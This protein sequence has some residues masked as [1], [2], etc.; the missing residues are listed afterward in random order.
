MDGSEL[1]SS[2][3]RRLKDSANL[4]WRHVICDALGLAASVTDRVI[5][6]E[7][8]HLD[9][10]ST[11][12][13][14]TEVHEI[15]PQYQNL[16]RIHCATFDIRGGLYEDLPIIKSRDGKDHH[17][18][19]NLLV[20]DFYRYA[21]RQP[22]ISFAVIHEF[23]CCKRLRDGTIVRNPTELTKEWGESLILFSQDLYRALRKL[24]TK[25]APSAPTPD[26]SAG[27]E[28]LNWH[29]WAFRNLTILQKLPD[30]CDGIEK[31][32]A[33]V[34][35]EYFCRSKLPDFESIKKLISSGHFSRQLL[36][37][38]FA[39][40]DIVLSKS[41][42]GESY[43]MCYEL[44]G[45][46]SYSDEW[47]LPSDKSSIPS[48]GVTTETKLELSHWLFDGNFMKETSSFS[49]KTTIEA[50]EVPITSLHIMPLTCLTPEKQSSLLRRG[51]MFWECRKMRHVTY[52]GWDF[53]RIENFNNVRFVIDPNLSKACYRHDPERP[54]QP[55]PELV[56]NLGPEAMSRTESPGDKFL[57]ATPNFVWG[58]NLQDKKWC[59]LAIAHVNDV[60]WDEKAFDNLVID[61]D[62][63]DV[64]QALV[65]NKVHNSTSTDLVRGKGGGL[66]LLLHG[67]PGTGKTL[68]AE[69]VAEHA[70]KPIYKVTCGDIG[71]KPE[72]V[73]GY[74]KKV[75][76]LGKTW[77]CIVLLDEAEVFLQERSL[78]DIDRNALVSVFLRNLEYYDGILILT[79]NRVATFDE[80]FRSRIQLAI[81]YPKLE[82]AERRRVWENFVNR[83]DSDPIASLEINVRNI[84]SNLTELS[85]FH[86]N[87][88][89]IRNA[90][91][92]ARPL[93]K[94]EGRTVDF[95]SLKKVI[96]VQQRFDKYMKE[97]HEGR[98]N[99]EVAR[100]DGKR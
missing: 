29:F 84:R 19:A 57:L 13:E 72:A 3:R 64:I 47:S 53:D 66:I 49:L 42:R 90:I 38:L 74:L 12:D 79:S 51:K 37:Y 69:S 32:H 22:G 5:L 40:G 80:G 61:P 68:T 36:G 24:G 54:D 87:G 10:S 55:K 93:A 60:D 81:H 63:K 95:E 33:L 9:T 50:N 39:P 4:G 45:W 43:D 76:T 92:V 44:L 31:K 73:E 96:K 26:F 98:D 30:L 23:V 15:E 59:K 20:T 77:D 14:S 27:R 99:E 58:F 65:T 75:L 70:K 71:T 28:S 6:E 21:Q 46:P 16:Y 85:N 62:S 88:R 35:S 78:E 82:Q 52:S 25:E 34:F 41:T 18:S 2:K 1:P 91:N 67:P 100:E 11:D 94:S 56:D 7:L 86:L 17:L 8:A 89:E 97:V 83:L 48:R